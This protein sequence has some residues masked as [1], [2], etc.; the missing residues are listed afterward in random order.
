MG[1]STNSFSREQNLEREALTP[2]EA[3]EALGVSES[4]VKR[5]CDSA[6]I[7]TVRTPGGHRRIPVEAVLALAREG[8]LPV[9]DPSRLSTDDAPRSTS[10]ATASR[11]LVRALLA[12]DEARATLILDAQRRAASGF[13]VVAD[14]VITPALAALGERWATGA[15]EVY[16][17]RRS[18]GL[19]HGC[20]HAL[21][22]QI[23][24][25][26]AGAPEALGGT[27]E[28]DPF[29][30]ATSLVE[31]VLRERGFAARSLGS[32]LPATTLVRAIEDHRPRLVW[33]SV[34]HVGERFTVD[35]E[36]VDRAARRVGAALVI[37]GR[38][39]DAALRR[40]LRYSA[41]CDGLVQLGSF[42]EALR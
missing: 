30:I 31:L 16:E 11:R 32:W 35:Y 13:D 14:E 29:T 33:L 24:P 15:L 28:G 38:A 17:E 20:L 34:G 5:W 41:F 39:L 23:A 26:A 27:L 42:A 8:G 19:L 10:H 36:K 37:G 1:N 3:A 40:R 18:C 7:R 9:R 25:A 22:K 6:R 21:G 4:S 2:R 12:D